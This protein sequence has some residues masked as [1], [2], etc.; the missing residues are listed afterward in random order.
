MMETS[1]EFRQW[2]THGLLA[3][4]VKQHTRYQAELIK[5][6]FKQAL[7]SASNEEDWTEWTCNEAAELESLVDLI[8]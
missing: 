4:A 5:P 8:K 3:L 6:E 1:G 7:K 2:A